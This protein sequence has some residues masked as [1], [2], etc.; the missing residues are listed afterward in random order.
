MAN[1]FKKLS[2]DFNVEHLEEAFT[3]FL[4]TNHQ[5]IKELDKKFFQSFFNERKLTKSCIKLAGL[6]FERHDGF[7][8]IFLEN[9]EQQM[10]KKELMYPL[11]DLA[12]KKNLEINST[13]LQKNYQNY[14]NGFMRTI[15]KPLKAGMIYKVDRTLYALKRVQGFL[16]QTI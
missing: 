3:N 6:V 13:V 9:L 5:Y 15:E 2:G 1:F 7:N 12:F 8:G 14:K 16:Q 11:I 4:L 10:D